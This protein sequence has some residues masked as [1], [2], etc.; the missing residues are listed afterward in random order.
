MS[1][2]PLETDRQDQEGGTGMKV[3]TATSQTQGSRDNDFCCA[4]EGELV[5]FPPIECGHGYVDD[6]CGCRRSMA[7]LASHL[8]TTTVKVSDR[9][10]IDPATYFTLIS[11]GLADMGYVTEELRKDPEVIEWLHDT[12]AELMCIARAFPAGTVLERRGDWVSVRQ[13]CGDRKL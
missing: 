12:T 4:V 5:L 9:K 11:E 8:S 3:L 6:H 1:V 13:S 7:G 2:L 10:E